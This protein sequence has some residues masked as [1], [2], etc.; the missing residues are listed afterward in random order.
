[1]IMKKYSAEHAASNAF[2]KKVQMEQARYA[3][4]EPKLKAED[5]KFDACMTSDGKSARAFGAKLAAKM[6]KA[7]PVKK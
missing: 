5:M 3:G 1:M 4:K 2:V 7:F 6:D